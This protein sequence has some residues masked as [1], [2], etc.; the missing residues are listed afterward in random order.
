M[1][2]KVSHGKRGWKMISVD[3]QDCLDRRIED[4]L[5]SLLYEELRSLVRRHR[6][7]FRW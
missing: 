2:P 5:G 6:S 1:I 3:G 4:L 7:G